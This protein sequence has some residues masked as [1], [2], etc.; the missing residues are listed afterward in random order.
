ML[1][2]KGVVKE[3]FLIQGSSSASFAEMRFAG[4]YASI[5]EMRVFASFEMLFQSGSSNVYFPVLTAFMISTSVGP[6]KGGYPHKRM[7]RMTPHDH[8]SHF[9]S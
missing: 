9:S 7:Y 3:L 5:F 6:L 8:T 2:L 1:L 4:V